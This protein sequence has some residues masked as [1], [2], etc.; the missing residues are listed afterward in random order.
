MPDERFNPFGD[1]PRDRPNMVRWL[2]KKLNSLARKSLDSELLSEIDTM[3]ESLEE[4]ESYLAER[5]DLP[6]SAYSDDFLDKVIPIWHQS[7][8]L[9]DEP[10]IWGSWRTTSR[11]QLSHGYSAQHK[12]TVIREKS[13]TST[14]YYS[15]I[16]NPIVWKCIPITQKDTT[17][18]IVISKASELDAA[19]SVPSFNKTLE[20]VESGLR[21]LDRKREP[22]EWQRNPD[23]NRIAAIETFIGDPSNIVAN[24]PLVFAPESKH[25]SYSKSKDGLID[26]ITIDFSFLK[27]D[28]D[29][30]SDH[31]ELED[32][33]P[34]WL[35]DGQHRVR[36]ISQNRIS[37]EL[38]M[39]FV[40]FP[41][42]LGVVSAAKI[43]AEVNTLAK[44]LS[45]L[46][47]IFM[48][49]R[50]QIPSHDRESDFRPFHKGHPESNY[51]R[52]N[53]LS[54]E[55]AAFLTSA[56]GSPLKSQIQIL[57][58]NVDSHHII[59]AKMFMKHSTHW[60]DNK[61]P[62]PVNTELDKEEI[63]TEI[64]NY[65][66]A[67]ESVANHYTFEGTS[68]EWQD[69]RIRWE[70]MPPKQ[71]RSAIQE[72]RNF[73]AI[74]RLLPTAVEVCSGSNRPI[75]KQDFE[76]ALLPITWVDWRD[77]DLIQIFVKK[78]GEGP[79]KSLLVWLDNA[80]RNGETFGLSEVM[81]AELESQ[82]GKGILSRPEQPILEFEKDSPTWPSSGNPAILI[83]NRPVNSDIT[84]RWYIRD[85]KGN[86]RN[87][88]VRIKANRDYSCRYEVKYETWM[89]ANQ[90]VG[91]SMEIRVDWGNAA[92]ES[93]NSMTLT[94]P[95]GE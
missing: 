22:K 6:E 66:L 63:F 8:E 3:V 65:F 68:D 17:F 18:Y 89:S 90:S 82:H 79:W 80:I 93:S 5:S 11:R 29:L 19:C 34:L 16:P 44:D 84:S 69:G 58:E 38:D 55:C 48:R 60:F 54:Y 33:R 67:L 85:T 47:K 92:G 56:I 50:F 41:D 2:I 77:Q 14:H 76:R 10:L 95:G 24:T 7:C 52:R 73:R 59:D 32:L 42:D 35:I 28:G 12:S 62:Y 40:F 53:T 83:S 13:A 37:T 51:S 4:L 9:S 26:E 64:K 72:T 78:T 46:H 75:S 23:P 39:P 43:F 81:S 70:R 30:F 31:D 49:H 25:V 36:G 88:R 91:K 94:N 87:Q 15:E 20:T 45:D 86:P 21:V 57:D 74:L 27:E 71:G 1:E 61:G